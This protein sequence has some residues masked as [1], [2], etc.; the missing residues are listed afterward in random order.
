MTD[1]AYEKEGSYLQGKADGEDI[2]RKEERQKALSEKLQAA[3]EMLREG[4]S[5]EKVCRILK[6]TEEQV[7]AL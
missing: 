5:V 7:K 3:R 1:L 6:L 4:D 2:G